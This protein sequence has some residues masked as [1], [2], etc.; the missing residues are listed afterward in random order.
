MNVPGFV[1]PTYNMDAVTFDAQR[2]VNMYPIASEV[3]TSKSVSALR[4]APG[5]D[6]FAEAGGGPIR[7]AKTA[8]N[9]RGF[10]MSA[11]TVLI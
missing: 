2:C 6:L 1:G 7:G 9:G 3:G 8:A 10:V 4:S 5:Y 11:R